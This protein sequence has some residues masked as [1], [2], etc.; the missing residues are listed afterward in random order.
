MPVIVTGIASHYFGRDKYWT[1]EELYRRFKDTKFKVGE[2]DKG[3][4]LRVKLKHYLEY[5]VH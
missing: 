3:R 1:W 2:D 4:K 5:L